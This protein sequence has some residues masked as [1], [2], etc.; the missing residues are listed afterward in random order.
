MSS[1]GIDSSATSSSVE[2]R[3]PIRTLVAANIGNATEWYD[4]TIYATFGIYFAG[5]FYPSDS[6]G[7]A[8]VKTSA[9]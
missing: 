1:G 2:H 3:L 7:L 6:P 5:Q 4:W 9:T 8:L